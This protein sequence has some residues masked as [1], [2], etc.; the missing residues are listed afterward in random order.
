MVDKLPPGPTEATVNVLPLKED[1]TAPPMSTPLPTL[2]PW[3]AAVVTV[4]TP[5]ATVRPVTLV[6]LAVTIAR[7]SHDGNT[8]EAELGVSVTS[9]TLR[10]GFGEFKERK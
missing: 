1:G 6:A 8:A 7:G 2:N 3:G 5:A 4:T 10:K 9:V